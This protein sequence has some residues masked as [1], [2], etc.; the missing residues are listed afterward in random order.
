M[1]HFNKPQEFSDQAQ[2]VSACHIECEGK[3]LLLQRADHKRIE[4][5]KRWVPAGKVD[6]LEGGVYETPHGAML[7]EVFE[8]TKIALEM[9]HDLQQSRKDLYVAL[10][11]ADIVFYV[12]HAVLNQMPC[13]VINPDEHKDFKR[14]TPEEALEMDLMEDE[15]ECIKLIFF[16]E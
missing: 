5:N 7:R 4:P 16:K 6:L 1:I 11:Y 12:F 8:E 3:V 2:P 13:V 9:S 15:A 10:S 14:V